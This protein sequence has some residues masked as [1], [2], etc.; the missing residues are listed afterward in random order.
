ML[1]TKFPYSTL[2]RSTASDGNRFYIDPVSNKPLPSVTTILSNTGD[3]TFLKEWV[4]R[5]GQKKADAIRDEAAALGT[6][7][8]T[9]LECHLQ[10][11]PRPRGSNLIR[12]Q[13]E[14]MAN[15]IIEKGLPGIDEVWGYEI[16][17]YFPNTYAGTTDVLGVHKG[18]PAIMDYK[19]TRKMKKKEM[20]EDYFCQGT[21]YALA[22]NEVYGTDI[23]KVVIFMVD[24]QLEYQEF[25][26]E[27][28][29]FNHYAGIF[30]TRLMTY[31]ESGPTGHEAGAVVETVSVAAGG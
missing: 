28:E 27:G 8:H 15:V 12:Q 9:H 17:L 24:R 5:V 23:A 7:M 13:A 18:A 4:A 14:R 3:K 2:E 6:L 22:H 29:E 16:P 21:A 30:L 11:I 26:I 20:I 1:N 31:M 10:N 25:V 19:N